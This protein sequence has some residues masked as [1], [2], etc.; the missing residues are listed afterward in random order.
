MSFNLMALLTSCVLLFL[1]ELGDKTQLVLLSLATRFRSGR[2]VFLGALSAEILIDGLAIYFGTAV[3]RIIPVASI[4]LVAS[5]AF[6]GLGVWTIWNN[7]GKRRKEEADEKVFSSRNA[8]LAA[9]GTIV[10]TEMGDKSQLTAGLLAIQL[11]HPFE[12]LLGVAVGLGLVTG[13]SIFAGRKLAKRLPQKQIH[14]LSGVLFVLF[15]L[16]FAFT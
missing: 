4:K 12:V 5:A 6:V 14:L 11:G 9:F 3:T 15:G 1:A 8:F 13:L 2:M 7:S 10:L 16:F